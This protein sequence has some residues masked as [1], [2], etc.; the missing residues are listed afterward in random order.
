MQFIFMN[1]ILVRCQS[2]RCN[3]IRFVKACILTALFLMP[4]TLLAQNRLGFRSHDSRLG[5][6]YESRYDEG[7]CLLYVY[8]NRA[9]AVGK[10]V[11]KSDVNIY[12]AFHTPDAEFF[13]VNHGSSR[14]GNIPV[15]FREAIP[16]TK[17]YISESEF[18][19][20]VIT[21]LKN[22]YPEFK[23]DNLHCLYSPIR[24]VRDGEALIHASGDFDLDPPRGGLHQKQF[25][26]LF[27]SMNLADRTIRP[28]DEKDGPKSWYRGLPDKDAT[29]GSGFFVTDRHILTNAHVV[30]VAKRVAVG[31]GN[32]EAWADVVAVSKD[33]DLA[34]LTI[35]ANS[36]VGIPVSLAPT[37]PELGQRVRA[38]GYPLP[39][40]QGYTLKATDGTISGLFGVLD[41]PLHFQTTAPMQP[42]NSGGALLDEHNQLVG[43]A[44]ASL[45]KIVVAK[46]TGTLSENVNFGIHLDVVRRFLDSQHVTIEPKKNTKFDPERSFVQVISSR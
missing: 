17:P 38:Y 20:M 37:T 44:V 2:T 11:F 9:D 33:Y 3:T 19:G 32:K 10:A 29:Y 1:I 12:C 41:N 16:G 22:I 28:L 30:G 39:M 23:D 35:A 6:F 34:L 40:V 18:R 25:Q 7:G 45:D 21:C 26:S 31:L 14:Y 15:V 43:V 24:D 46:A 36:L 4:L 42:G 27:L 5:Y 13:I 8:R